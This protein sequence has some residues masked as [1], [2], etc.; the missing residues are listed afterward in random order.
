[1]DSKSKL[2]NNADDLFSTMKK[3]QE[4][5]DTQSPN[6][7]KNTE[8]LDKSE[9][10]PLQDIKK[11]D[12]QLIIP[13]QDHIFQKCDS[14]NSKS[15]KNT[16]KKKDKYK[17]K[18]P[19]KNYGRISNKEKLNGKQGKHTIKNVDNGKK[20]GIVDCTR[21]IGFVINS[22][23]FENHRIKLLNPTITP[24]MGEKKTDE[25][26][27]KLFNK[28]MIEIYFTSRPKINSNNNILKMKKNIIKILEEEKKKN[29]TI[30]ILTILFNKTLREYLLMY[31]NDYPFLNYFN[32]E[33]MEQLFLAGFDTYK[34]GLNHLEP[35]IKNR[36]KCN[37]LKLLKQ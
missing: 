35:K 33:S 1:M 8:S 5:L 37:L 18:F 27:K 19:K 4:N 23:S 13:S 7:S 28:L 6:N 31:L 17:K 25:D 11:N 36:I 21:N 12:C 32:G 20:R 26:L 30:K 9:I 22:L 2:S 10:P 16:K 14:T 24:Q 34:G 15:N 29:E 3:G